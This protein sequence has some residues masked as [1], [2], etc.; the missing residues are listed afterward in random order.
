M[1][2]RNIV[3]VKCVAFSLAI[4]LLGLG[5]AWKASAASPEIT[6]KFANYFPPPSAYSKICEEFIADLEMRTNGRVKVR[7]FP[8]GTLLN[9]PATI[10]GIESG[11]TDI[12]VSHVAYTPGR[13]PVMEVIEMPIGYT[14]GWVANQVVNDFYNKFRPKDFDSVKLMWL[15]AN[16]PSVLVTSRPVRKLEDLKGMT[17]R[18]PGRFGDVISA[19]GGTPAP[20]PVVETYDALSKGVIQGV[21]IAIDGLRFIR[22]AEVAK[23]TTVVPAVGVA[24]AFYVAMNKNSYEKL[25]PDIKIIFDQLC[26]EYRERFALMW[27]ATEFD[28]KKFG[29]DNG[30]EYIVLQKEEADKWENA[31]SGVIDDYTKSMISKGHKEEEVREWITYLKQRTAELTAKQKEWHIEAAIVQ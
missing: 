17:I 6:L 19:L 10:K 8:G 11:I 24:Y 29:D 14:T 3:A 7:Y 16:S 9:A 18:A 28:G 5:L 13:M 15:H 25:P 4:V 31:V 2:A 1:T 27:N 12:G 22:L 30:V 26:G 20:T 23:Y 21:L